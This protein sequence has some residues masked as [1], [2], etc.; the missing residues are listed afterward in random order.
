MIYRGYE[1]TKNEDG[2]WSI[3]SGGSFP[4]VNEKFASDEAAMNWIDAYKRRL[5]AR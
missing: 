4:L 2:S 1:I 3:H 5:A